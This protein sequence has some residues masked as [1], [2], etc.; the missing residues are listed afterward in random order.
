MDV[1]HANPKLTKILDDGKLSY[2]QNL[3]N[4]V[5]NEPTAITSLL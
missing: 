5:G 3:N 4:W 1:S 2:Q